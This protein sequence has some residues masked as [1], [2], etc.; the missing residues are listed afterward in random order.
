MCLV[1]LFYGARKRYRIR[2]NLFLRTLLFQIA[3][4]LILPLFLGLD[5]IWLAIVAAELL[6]LIVTIGFFV[7][8]GK[9]YHYM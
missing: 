8:H 2:R 1:P 3:A 7:K 6:A 5:G 4:V 9:Y